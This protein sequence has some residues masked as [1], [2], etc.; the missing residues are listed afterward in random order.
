MQWKLSLKNQVRIFHPYAIV[1]TF[2]DQATSMH[3]SVWRKKINILS[4]WALFELARTSGM[5]FSEISSNIKL[6]DLQLG[7]QHLSKMWLQY[8]DEM[9]T[10]FA[11]VCNE[12][13]NSRDPVEI[14][15]LFLKIKSMKISQLINLR[16]SQK[17]LNLKFRMN[18]F[19]SCLRYFETTKQ[20]KIIKSI[21]IDLVNLL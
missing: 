7:Y 19:F 10:Y 18:F 1:L 5:K 16:L 17:S 6:G 21:N 13:H 14:E 2:L 9:E 11:K 8:P 15:T 3:D 4:G 12:L 20:K